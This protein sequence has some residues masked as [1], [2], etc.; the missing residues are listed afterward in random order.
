M[1]VEQTYHVL[2]IWRAGL[3]NLKTFFRVLDAWRHCDRRMTEALKVNKFGPTYRTGIALDQDMRS[4]IIDRIL[5]GGGDRVTGYIPRSFRYFS[6][7]LKLSVNTITKIWRKFCEE[8]SINPRA[9]GGTKWSKLTGDDLELIEILKIEKPSVSL[10][11]IISCLQEMDG[12]EVSTLLFPERSS[13]DCHQVLTREKKL[14][15]SPLNDLHK[16]TY[17]IHNF[18]SIIWQ[19]KTRD[20][21]NSL[22]K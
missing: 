18:S 6:E 3:T 5:Q 11:E 10:V 15:R 9:K 13:I 12:E 8:L 4:L 14:R 7:E 16:Q 1:F 22:T 21:L 2:L 20:G 17:F 19:Q